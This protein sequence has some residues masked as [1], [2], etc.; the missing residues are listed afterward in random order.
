ML[1]HVLYVMIDFKTHVVCYVFRAYIYVKERSID[2]DIRF[3]ILTPSIT[4]YII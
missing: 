1:F 2:T 4:F 3:C